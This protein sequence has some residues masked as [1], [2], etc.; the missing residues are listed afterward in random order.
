MP[1]GETRGVGMAEE[2]AAQHSAIARHDRQGEIAA[3]RQMPFRHALARC[4]AA[5]ALVTGDV[6]GTDNAQ[7]FERRRENGGV[8]RHGEAVKGLA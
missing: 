4:V 7:P 2:Q 6:V 1:R 8:A 3:H 5:I